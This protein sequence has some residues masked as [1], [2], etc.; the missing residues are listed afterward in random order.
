MRDRGLNKC[1][2]RVME[3]REPQEQPLAKVCPFLPTQY[4]F[5]SQILLN[6]LFYPPMIYYFLTYHV[7][8]HLNVQFKYLL[9]LKLSLIPHLPS[10][11]RRQNAY[12]HISVFTAI[13]IPHYWLHGVIFLCFISVIYMLSQDHVLVIALYRCCHQKMVLRQ[14]RQLNNITLNLLFIFIFSVS[15]PFCRTNLLFKCIFFQFYY[16]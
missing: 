10:Y 4:H 7:T 16:Y 3:S 2:S 5:L 13:H 6:P 12:S 1:S 11:P 8:I 15:P 14:Q 9:C